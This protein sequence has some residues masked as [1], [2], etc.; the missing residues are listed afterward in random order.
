MLG[1]IVFRFKFKRKDI[2]SYT[3]GQCLLKSFNFKQLSIHFNLLFFFWG[4]PFLKFIYSSTNS[5]L[6]PGHAFYDPKKSP[7]EDELT[8]NAANWNISK[9]FLRKITC[10]TLSDTYLLILWIIRATL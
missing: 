6:A 8:V 5:Y 3:S 4:D 10:S 7:Q 2:L 9:V 1:E